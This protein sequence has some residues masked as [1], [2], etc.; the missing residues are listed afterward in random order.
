MALLPVEKIVTT[1]IA[2]LEA[3]RPVFDTLVDAVH[4]GR[5]LTIFHGSRSQI[6][7][8]QV[9]SVEVAALEDNLSWFGCRVQQETP[10]L[11]ID[12]TVDNQNPEAADR[13]LSSLTSLTTRIL[14]HPF[15]LLPQ[16]EGTQTH[17]FD[18]LPQK[19]KY[20][21]AQNGRQRVAT[22][23]WEGKYLEYLSNHLFSPAL[24]MRKSVG[25]PP[26]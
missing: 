18:S 6:P 15:H 10:T 14:A 9:P 16:I 3:E 19:A 17:L 21:T 25:F 26:G 7:S 4:P 12:V 20:G 5:R 22:I 1:I 8:N 13:L 24:R 2:W 11:R 23:L